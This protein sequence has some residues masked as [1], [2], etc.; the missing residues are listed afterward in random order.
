MDSEQVTRALQ[1]SAAPAGSDNSDA[2]A[3]LI[4]SPRALDNSDAANA[5]ARA[6]T[7]TT[8]TTLV[9]E[10]Q[11]EAQKGPEPLATAA[12]ASAVTVTEPPP[13]PP[14]SIAAVAEPVQPVSGG[15]GRGGEPTNDP[16]A[17]SIPTREA[18]PA[19]QPP[20]P[21]S[22][23]TAV[24]T[25]SSSSD[26]SSS[27]TRPATLPLPP[28]SLP[29]VGASA[30]AAPTPT[31]TSTSSPTP[32]AT[33]TAT[34]TPA[35]TQLPP[36]PVPA[37]PPPPQEDPFP[38]PPSPNPTAPSAP[39]VNGTR[40]SLGP[41]KSDWSARPEGQRG[42]GIS[43]PGCESCAGGERSSSLSLGS[44]GKTDHSTLVCL[45]CVRVGITSRGTRP[46]IQ[47]GSNASPTS[48]FTS[49]SLSLLPYHSR[50]S[51]SLSRISLFARVFNLLT[52]FQHPFFLL[53]SPP[54]LFATHLAFRNPQRICRAISASKTPL[55][56]LSLHAAARGGSSIL[57]SQNPDLLGNTMSDDENGGEGGGGGGGERLVLTESGRP[58]RSRAAMTRG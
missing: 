15:G 22:S 48:Q 37:P 31:P 34:A 50:F 41:A 14:S 27:A 12:A 19:P 39:P 43:G 49:L 2:S 38:P 26:P 40:C 33:A 21:S 24:D 3:P 25:A 58:K 10:V 42:V 46:S 32:S 6:T 30:S 57:Y 20:P 44:F 56:T 13:P 16:L 51:L 28:P 9:Q 29:A 5:P 17:G 53:P 45:S 52:W 35:A 36:N 23:T 55:P 54:L 4:G 1:T 18:E 7:T 11:D 47:Q 8:T